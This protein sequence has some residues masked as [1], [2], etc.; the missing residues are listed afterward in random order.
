MLGSVEEIGKI[1]VGNVVARDNVGVG[2][3]EELLP[4]C[5]HILLPVMADN[6]GRHDGARL[7]ETKHIS[8][9]RLLFSVPGHDI[10]NLDNGVVVGLWKD[11][12]AACALDIK[13][14]YSQGRHLGPLS[15]GL[16][17]D[18]V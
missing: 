4:R 8:D 13:G 9:K 2:L 7:V 14:Q 6:M 16:V 18:Q 17:G 10:G 3:D 1:K 12:L 5:Q 11:T 15:D